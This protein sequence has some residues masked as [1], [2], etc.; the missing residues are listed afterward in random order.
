MPRSRQH[1]RAAPDVDL[2]LLSD[3]ARETLRVVGLLLWAGY[4]HDVIAERTGWPRR[5]IERRLREF[6]AEVARL[7]EDSD[8]GRP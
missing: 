3:D 7:R 4:S 2:S 1:G 5:K 8:A 6:R